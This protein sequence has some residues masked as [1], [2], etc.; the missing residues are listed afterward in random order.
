MS[1]ILRAFI[2]VSRILAAESLRSEQ[3]FV[4]EL[5]LPEF[6]NP[7]GVIGYGVALLGGK[8]VPVFLILP[9]PDDLVN[10]HT[11]PFLYVPFFCNRPFS[12]G[13]NSSLGCRLPF[14]SASKCRSMAKPIS[15]VPG[16][17]G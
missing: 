3:T 14:L 10:R 17:S 6:D 13:P 5:R 1:V 9:G 12:A 11:I 7:G 15:N 4:F 16:K 2:R 8:R